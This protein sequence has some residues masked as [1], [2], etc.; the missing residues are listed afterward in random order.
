MSHNIRC[1][2]ESG[3]HC[4]NTIA[5]IILFPPP[6]QILASLSLGKLDDLPNLTI[7]HYGPNT[8]GSSVWPIMPDPIVF[9][10]YSGIGKII[11][12]H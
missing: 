5:K 1:L 2:Q 11:Q 9:G 6:L 4:A 10:P 12:Y 8:M 7:L 3:H